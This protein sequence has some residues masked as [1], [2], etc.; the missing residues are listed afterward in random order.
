VASERDGSANTPDHD[1]GCLALFL[2][3]VF[4][5]GHDPFEPVVGAL[6]IPGRRRVVVFLLA[7]GRRSHQLACVDCSPRL[8][9]RRSWCCGHPTFAA[10]GIHYD[11]ILAQIAGSQPVP[12]VAD[13]FGLERQAGSFRAP[14][15]FGIWMAVV[16][17]LLL[18]A[19]AEGRPRARQI[20]WAAWVVLLVSVAVLTAS[21]LATTGPPY[22]IPWPSDS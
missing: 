5:R 9:R 2:G 1:L 10:L 13:R 18:P 17:A 11:H 15:Y 21:R 3:S 20:A 19:M 7:T 4:D 6:R 8:S 14:L 12:Q 22:G 16:S